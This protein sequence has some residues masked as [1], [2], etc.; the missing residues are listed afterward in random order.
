M[1]TGHI[2]LC[3]EKRNANEWLWPPPGTCTCC[4]KPF[5]SSNL[6]TKWCISLTDIS[7]TEYNEGIITI[8]RRSLPDEKKRIESSNIEELKWFHKRLR[9]LLDYGR[10]TSEGNV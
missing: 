5:Y 10:V 7:S 6:S 1:C 3:V 2:W 9:K 8:T 4:V